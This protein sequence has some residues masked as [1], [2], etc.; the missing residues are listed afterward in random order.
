MT[1]FSSLASNSE[2]CLMKVPTRL[3]ICS[4]SIIL[5]EKMRQSMNKLREDASFP[6]IDR[7][8]W[9]LQDIFYH[10]SANYQDHLESHKI[11]DALDVLI[12]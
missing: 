1:H 11:I 8:V 7:N 5:L 10:L 9:L 3:Y 4:F 12:G 2:E 6:I